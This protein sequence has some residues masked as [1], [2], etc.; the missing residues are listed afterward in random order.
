MNR[1]L[2]FDLPLDLCH[3]SE[4][5]I[6]PVSTSWSIPNSPIVYA[7]QFQNQILNSPYLKNSNSVS[8]R[9]DKAYLLL[10]VQRLLP[11]EYQKDHIEVHYILVSSYIDTSRQNYLTRF[12]GSTFDFDAETH[13]SKF[14]CRTR[15]F[16]RAPRAFFGIS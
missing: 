4:L 10:S 1:F 14:L 2:P 12:F 3:E 7:I 6:K 8:L 13:A 16:L 5:M 11:L 9:H 15:Q